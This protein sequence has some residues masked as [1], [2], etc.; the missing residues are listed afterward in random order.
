MSHVCCKHAPYNTLNFSTG[1]S[2]CASYI[3]RRVAG[4][5]L[6]DCSSFLTSNKEPVNTRR[7]LRGRQ[8]IYK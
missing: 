4:Q 3:G 2:T 7:G 1:W 5:F 8:Y 6:G